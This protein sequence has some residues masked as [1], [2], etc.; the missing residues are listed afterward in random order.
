MARTYRFDV[1]V[2]VGKLSGHE[3]VRDLFKVILHDAKERLEISGLEPCSFSYD[4]LE[5]CLAKIF[6]YLHVNTV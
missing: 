3:D 5:D 6:G 1:T 2:H 4:V